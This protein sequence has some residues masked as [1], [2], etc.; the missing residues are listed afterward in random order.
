[1]RDTANRLLSLVVR[2]HTQV[3]LKASERW[4]KVCR[5][6]STPASQHTNS[7]ESSLF[8][9]EQL[10]EV[11]D[12]AD[13]LQKASVRAGA[14]P[15]HTPHPKYPPP[16]PQHSRPRGQLGQ[17]FWPG[18]NNHGTFEVL[19]STTFKTSKAPLRS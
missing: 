12:L 2:M 1:M 4:L 6:A 17:E 5:M 13:R 8:A 16:N 18:L 15:I 10:K 19:S 11:G 3:E 7:S 9:M 14:P